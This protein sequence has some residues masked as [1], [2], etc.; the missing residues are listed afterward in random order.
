[1]QMCERHQSEMKW[2]EGVG[3]TS[4][5]PYAFWSCS[6]KEPD[7]SWCKWKPANTAPPTPVQ[8]F[9]EELNQAAAQMNSGAKDR[10]ITR[11]AVAKSL[12]EAGKTIPDLETLAIADRWVRWI[13]NKMPHEPKS[14][15]LEYGID[16]FG[17]G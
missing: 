17:Q 7:G 10:L 4:G 15:E 11:T 3:K 16:T 14:S 2:K 13:D 8:R 5:K 12:I 1:M 6:Q 9:N